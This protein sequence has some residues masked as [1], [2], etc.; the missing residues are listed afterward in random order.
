[1]IKAAAQVAETFQLCV[2]CRYGQVISMSMD[3]YAPGGDGEGVAS[4]LNLSYFVCVFSS[5]IFVH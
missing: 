4:S 2:T 3:Y 1:M 5:S